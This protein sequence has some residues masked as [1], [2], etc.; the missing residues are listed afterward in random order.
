M[1]PYEILNLGKDA[2]SDDVK[3]AYRDRAKEAHPDTGGSADKFALVK[4]AADI[5]GDEE[6]RKK[7][8][9]TGSTDESSPDNAQSAIHSEIAWALAMS[10]QQAEMSGMVLEQVDIV[11]QMDKYLQQKLISAKTDHGTATK[12]MDKLNRVKGRFKVNQGRNILSDMIQTQINNVVSTIANI[13]RSI[14]SGTGALALLE[15]Y[16]FETAPAEPQPHHHLDHIATQFRW[17]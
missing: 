15:G 13:D 12:T 8:D 14:E 7:F 17:G 6:R 11:D 4:L 9:E 10:M 1:D 3:K 5:L 16:E 2:T